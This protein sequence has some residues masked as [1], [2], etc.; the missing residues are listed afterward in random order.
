[1]LPCAEVHWKIL[2]AVCRQIAVCMER[3]KIPRSKIASA[4]GASQAAISQYLSGKR[5]GAVPLPASA[6]KK[7]EALAKRYAC[8]KISQKEIDIGV[9]MIVVSVKKSR[10][11]KN[12]PCAICARGGK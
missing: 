9:S 3:E 6:V 7:C 5:G 12:D 4:L 11:G 2:P 10:L 8:G 1:M